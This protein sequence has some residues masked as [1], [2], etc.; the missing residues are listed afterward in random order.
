VTTESVTPS[1]EALELAVARRDRAAGLNEAFKILRAVDERYG[2]VD[3]IGGP[4][5]GTELWLARI[6]TRFCAAFGPLICD[7]ETV[8]TPAVYEQLIAHH[9]WIE[10]MFSASGF[11]S[12]EHLIPLL[13]AGEGAAKRV[14]KENLARFLMLYSAAAGM[15]VNLDEAASAD[16]PAAIG[17]SLGYLGSRFCFTDAGHAFREQLVEWLPLRLEQVKLGGLAL[18]ALASPYM[19]CSYASSPAKHAMK[20]PM[21]AQMRRGCLEAGCREW[22]PA[23]P[24]R[25]E[26]RPTIVVT[27]ENF[28]LNHSIWRTHS[29]SVQA[30]RDLFRVVGFF[31]PQ[32]LTPEVAA[33]FDEA[34]PYAGEGGFLGIVRNVA[35]EVLARTPAMVLHLGVGM[36]PV[37]IALA[38]LRLAPVQAVSFGHTATTAS[39]VIDHMILP[40]DFI[41]D[42]ALFTENLVRLPAA[43][44]PYRVR[45]GLGDE[46]RAADL[47]RPGQGRG[48]GDA[49][50]RV[51]HLPARL[52]GARPRRADAAPRAP[53]AHGGDPSGA[54]LRRLPGAAGRLRL[55]RLPLPLWEHEQHRRRGAGRAAGRLPRRTR[56]PRP[57]RRRLFPPPGLSG[58][59]DRRRRGG[60]CGA[61][62]E[63]RGRPGL[64]RRV[65]RHRRQGRWRPPVL[66][67]RRAPVRGGGGRADHA[68]GGGLDTKKPP[69]MTAEGFEKLDREDAARHVLP[70]VVVVMVPMAMM[71]MPRARHGRPAERDGEQG[72]ENER[73]QHEVSPASVRALNRIA[74]ALTS[75][76]LHRCNL[77]SG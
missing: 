7:P 6:T 41:G 72:G 20:A 63:A 71:V 67:R 47:R 37:V 21:M 69:A 3:G 15:G 30:L 66:R 68:A 54:A 17:A 35:D 73:A 26:T 46:T 18:Q 76:A 59:A 23:Q 77:V 24:R 50:R 31:Y 65:P 44:M 45:D 53:P 11:A 36:S 1:L 51:P 64:A 40:D 60:V 32:H 13:A 34:L 42:P 43:A 56:G 74:R 61:D 70:A 10:L 9:R 57:R 39:P 25:R 33:C 4:A 55:L 75:Q 28:S 27:T 52:L 12:A 29:R 19:H 16:P 48:H 2:R 38:S 14:P 22:D 5:P 58:G 49:G 8:L 62:R